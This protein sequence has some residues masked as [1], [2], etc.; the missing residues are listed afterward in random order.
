MIFLNITKKGE[1]ENENMMFFFILIKLVIFMTIVMFKKCMVLFF[2]F[3]NSPGKNF[4][5]IKL[6]SC[7][8]FISSLKGPHAD[9]L[10]MSP[11]SNKALQEMKLVLVEN[12]HVEE[13][14]EESHQDFDEEVAVKLIEVSFN[15]SIHLFIV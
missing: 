1:I 8:V 3:F 5:I 12:D 10:E 6:Y 7:L 13:N 11:C 15:L 2:Y 14:K 4:T 9:N